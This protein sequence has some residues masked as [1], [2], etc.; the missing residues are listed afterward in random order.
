MGG[1]GEDGHGVASDGV[2]ECPLFAEIC[3]PLVGHQAM[4]VVLDR[5][6]R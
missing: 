3:C 1:D 2:T 5:E 6:R 4:E